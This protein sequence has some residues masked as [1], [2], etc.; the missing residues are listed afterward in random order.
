MPSSLS[1]AV[2][3]RCWGPRAPIGFDRR[4]RWMPPD[5]AS[6]TAHRFRTSV[7]LVGA[8]C[9]ALCRVLSSGGPFGLACRGG[10]PGEAVDRFQ[11]NLADSDQR[12]GVDLEE[13]DGSGEEQPLQPGIDQSPH[14][15]F[16]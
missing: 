14:Q 2:D 12:H 6:Y 13:I 3:C 15:L 11:V 16:G 8:P 5:T 10:L 1:R 7:L 9:T 4:R